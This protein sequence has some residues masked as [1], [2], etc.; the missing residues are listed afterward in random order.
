MKKKWWVII[1]SIVVIFVGIIAFLYYYL[2]TETYIKCDDICWMYPEDETCSPC[3]EPK[4]YCSFYNI[5]YKLWLKKTLNNFNKEYGDDCGV[6]E[7][8][9]NPQT[10]EERMQEYIECLKKQ[11]E[12]Y[13]RLKQWYDVVCYLCPR[14]QE[15][16]DLENKTED[17][18]ESSV[19]DVQVIED[20]TDFIEKGCLIYFDW[21]N[22]YYYE[23]GDHTENLC[24]EYEEPECLKYKDKID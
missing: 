1:I 13:E 3:P 22:T 12:C 8:C 11:E 16:I 4:K 7:I 23:E 24:L 5:Q 17:K 15:I 10:E 6:R 18:S 21:C 20:E 14:F 19:V 2:C 9:E